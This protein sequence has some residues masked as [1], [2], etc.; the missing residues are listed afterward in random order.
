M[1]VCISSFLLWFLYVNLVMY[2]IHMC[3]CIYVC[4]HVYIRMFVCMYVMYA[5]VCVCVCV[6][7]FRPASSHWR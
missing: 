7:M 2:K 4:V 5:C 3:V 1:H 6:C